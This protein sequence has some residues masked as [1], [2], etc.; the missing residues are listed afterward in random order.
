MRF[1]KIFVFAF[2]LVACAGS[3]KKSD[4]YKWPDQSEVFQT[5]TQVID[6]MQSHNVKQ[7][8]IFVT[9]DWD[10]EGSL[11]TIK[12]WQNK[13]GVALPFYQIS[14]DTVPENEIRVLMSMGITIAV[15][16][17]ILVDGDNPGYFSNG[18]VNCTQGLEEELKKLK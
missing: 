1:I 6:Y 5:F 17:C 13:G 8:V 10:K 11:K 7:A 12:Y 4:Q 16:L 9:A 14:A 3:Q 18:Y 15:P 2:C